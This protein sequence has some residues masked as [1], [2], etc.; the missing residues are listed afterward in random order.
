MSS[1]IVERELSGYI[2]QLQEQGRYSEAALL[3]WD[4]FMAKGGLPELIAL[5][6]CWADRLD[7]TS[8]K[9]FND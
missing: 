3:D 7:P 8:G 9:D 6:D 1:Q 5:R 4:L 2:G